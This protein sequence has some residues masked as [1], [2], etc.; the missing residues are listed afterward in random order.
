MNDEYGRIL[1]GKRRF[2]KLAVFIL[3]GKG[4]MVH[5]LIKTAN[6]KLRKCKELF[7][8]QRFAREAISFWKVT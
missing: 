7:H 3:K 2:E 4:I 1:D 8:Y 6:Q 5:P